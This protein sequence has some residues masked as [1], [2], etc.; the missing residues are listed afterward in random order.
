MQGEAA[1]DD[2][3]AGASYPEGLAKTINELAILNNKFSV[4]MK[5]LSIEIRCLL[6]LS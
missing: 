3:E 4:W 2:V 1:S 5:W 6:G